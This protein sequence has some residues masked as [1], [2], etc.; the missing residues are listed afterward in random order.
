MPSIPGGIPTA[1]PGVFD[2]THCGTVAG[3]TT[4]LTEPGVIGGIYVNR[5]APSANVIV[6]DSI[7]TSGTVVGTIP[8]GTST[9]ALV[10]ANAIPWYAGIRTKNGLTIAHPADVDL[11]VAAA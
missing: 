4:I 5:R 11:T 8:F 7:G 9:F 1:H 10:E 6:Y 2:Y 3:T